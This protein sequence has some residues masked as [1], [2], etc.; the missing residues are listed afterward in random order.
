ME[1]KGKQNYTHWVAILTSTRDSK[2]ASWLKQRLLGYQVPA[3]LA[4]KPSADGEVPVRIDKIHVVEVSD[5]EGAE[6]PGTTIDLLRQSRYLVV[7]CS[8]ETAKSKKAERLVAEFKRGDREHRVQCLIVDGEPFASSRLEPDAEECLPTTI[9]Y[10]VD[11]NGNLTDTP[12]S[13]YAA[14]V[15][16]HRDGR[17][18]SFLR[19]FAG[20]LRVEY[21][22][23]REWDHSEMQRKNFHIMIACSLLIVLLGIT[24]LYLLVRVTQ[25]E[26]S[27]GNAAE[28]SR[29]LET[30]IKKLKIDIQ[31]AGKGSPK[32]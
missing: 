13:P 4:G 29:Q 14:D 10:E 3:H 21:E 2:W 17:R 26:L 31:D 6:L 15:R 1:P 25:A 11:K 32:P 7:I 20:I 19:I 22:D 24:S 28:Y 16:Q 18:N 8:P 5:E 30:E 27:A 9:K 12:S 23:L